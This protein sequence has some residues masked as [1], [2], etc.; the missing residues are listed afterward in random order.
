MGAETSSMSTSSDRRPGLG[1]TVALAGFAA[2]LVYG[3]FGA[4]LGLGAPLIVLGFG[5][6][7]IAL[8]GL[9]LFRMLD[10]LLR[11]EGTLPE[12]RRPS[13][14]K[15]EL[16]REKQLVLKAIREIENDFQ[17]RKTSE[18]DYK[19]MT[20][21]YRARAMRLIREIDAGDDYRVLIEQ[22]LKTRLAALALALRPCP[23]CKTEND[24][25]AQFC[26]KCGKPFAAEPTAP[27][28]IH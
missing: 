22:E 11:P 13:V 6:M 18:E 24:G 23:A 10:P 17:M 3:A 5:G 12:A 21:R 16:E 27:V 28:G 20:Q 26:K 9:A 4:K 25:D 8:C 14:R 19:E 1:T 7:T 2:A 15:R